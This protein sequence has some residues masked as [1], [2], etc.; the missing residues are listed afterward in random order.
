MPKF[1]ITD[2]LAYTTLAAIL[3][4]IYMLPGG[5]TMGRTYRFNASPLTDESLKDWL[6]ANGYPRA[7]VSRD[8]DALTI[9]TPVSFFDMRGPGPDWNALGYNGV[10]L[11]RSATRHSNWIALKLAAVVLVFTVFQKL[12]TRQASAQ[13]AE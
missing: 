5:I 3:S 13:Y 12:R 8:E 6:G 9:T 4:T 2:L 10:R 7:L 1:S 11:S